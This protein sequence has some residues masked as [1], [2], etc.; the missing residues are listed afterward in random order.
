MFFFSLE[1]VFCDGVECRIGRV[2][3][4]LEIGFEVIDFGVNGR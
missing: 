1:I 2:E 4:M 3:Y